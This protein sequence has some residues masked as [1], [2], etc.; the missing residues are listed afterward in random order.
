MNWWTWRDLRAALVVRIE[1]HVLDLSVSGC[2][3]ES[4]RSIAVGST[5]ILDVRGL[6][7]PLSRVA[8]V[9]DT[10]ERP[11]AAVRYLL[12]LEFLSMPATRDV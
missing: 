10:T 12:H 3:V 9:R 11:G 8:R 6:D 1:G 4:A 5:G 2:R 7:E